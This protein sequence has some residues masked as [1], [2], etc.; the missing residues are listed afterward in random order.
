MGPRR[1]LDL[2]LLVGIMNSSLYDLKYILDNM[3][4]VSGQ[5]GGCS[6]NTSTGVCGG[7]TWTIVP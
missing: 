6:S 1:T 5:M 2:N 7:Q 4:K 3:V